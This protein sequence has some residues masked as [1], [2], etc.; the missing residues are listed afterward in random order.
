VVVLKSGD[1]LWAA[2]ARA[3]PHDPL[4]CPFVLL[5]K[6]GQTGQLFTVK[7]VVRCNCGGA[8]PVAAARDGSDWLG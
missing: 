5:H 6:H 2:M 7:R 4:A 8:L 1:G 3:A